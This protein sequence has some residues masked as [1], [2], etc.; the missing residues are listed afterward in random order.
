M[1]IP[2][3]QKERVLINQG[4][5]KIAGVDE[6]G[7]GAWAG[8]IFA[9]A[10]ILNPKKMIKGLN[11]SKKLTEKNRDKLAEEIKKNSLFFSIEYL[12]NFEIDDFGV[13]KSNFKVICKAVEYLDKSPDYLL[14]DKAK[15]YND[16]FSVPYEVIVKGDAKIFSIS[17]AS[18]LAKTA[19]DEYMLKI[20]KKYPQYGF[21]IHKGYG[22]KLHQDRLAEFER[23]EIHR[24]SFQP[25]SQ[26]KLC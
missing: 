20:S 24:R 3:F 22:T 17:A 2:N 4:Y 8:P 12:D 9:A 14:I 13:G 16:H 19:R 21:E 15:I 18:I 25:I 7:R 5:S 26:P 11:D 1:S 6:A 23:C 10:V